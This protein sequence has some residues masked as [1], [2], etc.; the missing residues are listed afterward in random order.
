M[1]ML[2]YVAKSNKR[3]FADEIEIMGFGEKA[4]IG[5]VPFSSYCIKCTYY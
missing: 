1:D 3:I 4:W 5:K 2:G